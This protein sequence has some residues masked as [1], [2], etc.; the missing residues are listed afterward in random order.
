MTDDNPIATIL[1]IM[2]ARLD[3]E[4]LESDAW[5]AF[6]KAAQL[7]DPTLTL[8]QCDAAWYALKTKAEKVHAAERP[9]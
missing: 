9:R 6:R 3:A 2:V 5:K 4:R 1:R 7:G 8:E